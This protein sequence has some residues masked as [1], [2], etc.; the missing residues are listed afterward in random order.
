MDW[1]TK[2]KFNTWLILIL[3]AVN[4][5][6]VS[7]IWMQT[8]KERNP[9]LPPPVGIEQKPESVSLM[10]RT[11]N[12]S[13][14]Q[15]KQ[16][17][18]MRENHFA[19]SKIVNEKILELK[20]QIVKQIFSDKKDTVLVSSL[21]NQ[22]GALETDLEKLRFKHFTEFVSICTPG[23]KEI[24]EP[25]LMELYGRRPLEQQNTDEQKEF[26]EPAGNKRPL[27]QE[28]GKQ[29]EKNAAAPLHNKRLNHPTIAEKVRDF[30][31]QLN[32][33][34]EQIQNVKSIFE[35]SMKKMEGLEENWR[36]GE[37]VFEDGKNKIL[38]TEDIEVDKILN[39]NQ[40]N[41]FEQMKKNRKEK[42]PPRE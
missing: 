15:T 1:I 39:S 37:K 38:R 2:N 9:I 8:L 3:L 25:V 5:L 12:L 20:R 23:Q 29:L 10:Q 19:R 17:E 13:D 28:A 18:K 41:K 11:L 36:P 32:L 21:C 16:F 6:T 4:I 26:S 22:I 30:T 31:E 7:I 33:T 35:I 42:Q 40:K 24:F 34:D 14:E 27:N